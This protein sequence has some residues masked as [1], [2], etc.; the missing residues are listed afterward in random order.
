MLAP[1]DL[2]PLVE[3]AGNDGRHTYRAVLI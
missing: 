3:A 1:Q 2:L